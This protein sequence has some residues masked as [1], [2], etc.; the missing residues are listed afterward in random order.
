MQFHP[1]YFCRLTMRFNMN[2]RFY[3]HNRYFLE[4]LNQMSVFLITANLSI[5]ESQM[6][7]TPLFHLYC[8]LYDI[9]DTVNRRIC[10][11]EN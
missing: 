2:L 8:I 6:Y 11:V 5:T 7:P 4:I 10:V 9:I 1:N 3:I